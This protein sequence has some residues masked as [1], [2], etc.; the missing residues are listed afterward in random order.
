LQGLSSNASAGDN[1]ILVSTAG[2]VTITNLAGTGSRA[3]LADASG[4]L[5]APVSDARLK[6]NVRSISDEVDV[7]AILDHLR[8]VYFNFI[9]TEGVPLTEDTTQQIGVIADE[10]EQVLPELVGYNAPVNGVKYRY[11]RYELLVA[12]LIEVAKAQQKQ[13]NELRGQK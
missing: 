1:R 3:V 7:L 12:Y 5:S 4:A 10:V 13:I 8:G 6:T 2:V 9:P 11:N